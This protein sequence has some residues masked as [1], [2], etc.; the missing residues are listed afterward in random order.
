MDKE[1]NKNLKDRI[2]VE[3][4]KELYEILEKLKDY[5]EDI[6]HGSMRPS[7]YEVSKLLAFKVKKRGGIV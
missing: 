6:S 1:N 5:V 3:I 4:G 7:T 2:V